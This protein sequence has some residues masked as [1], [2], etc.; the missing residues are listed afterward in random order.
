LHEQKQNGN[1]HGRSNVDKSFASRERLRFKEV[2]AKKAFEL[3][4]TV[5]IVLETCVFSVNSK[6]QKYH[7][8]GNAVH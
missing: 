8:T 5:F 3:I 7:N 1:E 6:R 4:S 2:I